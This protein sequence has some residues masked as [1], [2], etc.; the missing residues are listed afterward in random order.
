MKQLSKEEMK[1][2]V[3]GLTEP[4][5]CKQSACTVY[6]SSTGTTYSGNCGYSVSGRW[7]TAGCECLTSLGFYVPSGGVS[8]CVTS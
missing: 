2:V 1:K 3:G 4:N 5:G 8:N 7:G 6:D